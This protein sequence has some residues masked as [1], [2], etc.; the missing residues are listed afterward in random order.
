MTGEEWRPIPGHPMYEVSDQGNV[1]SWHRPSGG[2]PR[3]LSPVTTPTG[4]RVARLMTPDRRAP[5]FVHRLVLLAF[6]GPVPEG[7]PITRHLN[8]VKTDNRLENLRYGTHSENELDKVAHGS[9]HYAS[10]PQCSNGHPYTPENVVDYAYRG[11]R[12][13]RVCLTC[14]RERMARFLSRRRQAA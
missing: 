4:Y 2:Q 1:R 10:R 6:V 13:Y 5:V 12:P 8:G 14:R 3:V 9:H 11:G 7:K